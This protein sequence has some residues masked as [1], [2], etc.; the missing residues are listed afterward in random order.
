[1]ESKK[2]IL[3]IDIAKG[4]AIILAVI[5]HA[6]PDA[7]KGFWIAGK[8]SIA[9]STESFIYS[10][11]MPLFFMCSGFLL[12]TKLSTGG[13]IFKQVS[14]RFR[15]LMIPY[16]F[17]SFMYLL[18]KMK[19]GALAATQLGDN[20]VIGI[21]FGNSPCFGA[22]FL[23]SLFFISII[24]L[25]VRKVNVWILLLICFAL[26][27]VQLNLSETY[28]GIQ[29]ILSNT[30]WLVMG[31]LV[32]KNYKIICERTGWL[33]L[34]ISLMIILL[35][36]IYNVVNL[37]NSILYRK[38]LMIIKTLAGISTSFSLCY[39]IALK[40]PQTIVAK[41]LKICGD[42]CMDIY[43]ISMFVLVPLRILYVNFGFMN[44]IPYWP[45]IIIASVL[46]VIVPIILSKYV[47][48]KYKLLRILLIG[49]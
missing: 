25:S 1:M 5:G 40:Y 38:S 2:R 17:L 4:L 43:I 15:R 21:V 7:V 9:A 22:W 34:I 24:V 48:R 6:F 14:S 11:H 28:K 27:Y 44:Y 10:F 35:I 31:C 32:R 49:G 30:L 12:Y 3:E 42:Y 19:G 16:L 39:I 13:G 45:W 37:D 29:S 33:Q 23:W 8:D 41:C 46:G 47:V 20:P 36:H 18:A 26:S